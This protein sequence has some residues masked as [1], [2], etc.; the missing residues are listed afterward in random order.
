VARSRQQ[1]NRAHFK[2]SAGPGPAEKL[3]CV[4]FDN[5]LQ[6]HLTASFFTV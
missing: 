6:H 3:T 2:V 4:D 1:A 5:G